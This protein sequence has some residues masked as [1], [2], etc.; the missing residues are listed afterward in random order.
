MQCHNLLISV[1]HR[2]FM[3]VRSHGAPATTISPRFADFGKSDAGG[4]LSFRPAIGL[5]TYKS[6]VAVP[7]GRGGQKEPSSARGYHPY[8]QLYLMY[9]DNNAAQ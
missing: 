5:R 2:T 4:C 3:Q 1:V 7:V 6:Y 9:K 8:L